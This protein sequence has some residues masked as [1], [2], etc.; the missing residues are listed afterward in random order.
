MSKC[1]FL[2]DFR[3]P[4]DAFAYTKDVSYLKEKWEI[5]RSYDEFVKYLNDNGLPSL[6]SFDHDLC[7]QH[8]NPNIPPEE[9]REKTGYEAAKFL[10][11]YHMN[12]PSQVFPK[13]LIHTQNTRGGENIYYYIKSYLRS[14]TL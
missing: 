12:N 3:I 11:E 9:Y 7:D 14:L 13:F 1:L 8:Y 5:V 2:D 10:V 4:W 6:V